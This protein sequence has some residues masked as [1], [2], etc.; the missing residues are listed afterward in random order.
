LVMVSVG[1]PSAMARCTH[2]RGID[3]AA[4]AARPV[5]LAHHQRARNARSRAAHR[6]MARRSRA[7]HEDNAARAVTHR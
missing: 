6:A 3:G 7:A 1:M 4:A 5:G 2:R